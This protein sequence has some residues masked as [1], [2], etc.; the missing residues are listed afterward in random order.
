MK[1]S[2]I[3]ASSGVGFETLKLAIKRGFEVTTLSRNPIELE[4]NANWTMLKGNALNKDDLNSV[5]QNADAVIVPL[6]TG[7][8]MKPTS[9]YTDFATTLLELQK[10]NN[11]QMPFIFL[12]GFGTGDSGLYNT[13]IMKLFFKFLLKD[14]YDNKTQMENMISSSS[15][16]WEMVRPGLLKD[17][18]LTQKYRIETKLY[19]GINI[20]GINRIDVADFMLNEAQ[21]PKYLKQYPALSQK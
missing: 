12:T 20:G 21:N 19:K 14:I 9:L 1:L 3:G 17:G 8:S 5:I 18:D 2:I 11:Y 10:Q 7:K 6:G 13:F 16:K 15:I 4:K